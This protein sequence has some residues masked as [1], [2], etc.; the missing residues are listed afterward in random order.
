MTTAR[1][2]L[3]KATET[4]SDE[5]LG[6]IQGLSDQ[7]AFFNRQPDWPTHQYHVGQDG[8]VAGIVHHVAAWKSVFVE[9]LRGRNLEPT[10]LSPPSPDFKGL[11]A[12]LRQANEDWLKECAALS[13]EAFERPIDVPG[14]SA[15]LTPLKMMATMLEHDIEHLGQINYLVELQKCAAFTAP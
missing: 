9:L 11:V 14:V 1:E 12:W 7:Q 8:S 10:D 5:L 4:R 6:A 3:T 2:Y 15:G 13:D